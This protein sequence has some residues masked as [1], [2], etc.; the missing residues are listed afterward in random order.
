M[1]VHACDLSAWEVH[2]CRSEVHGPP[3]SYLHSD[4]ENSLGYTRPVL[5]PPPHTHTRSR[6]QGMRRR[7]SSKGGRREQ[8]GD[9]EQVTQ[10]GRLF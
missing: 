6:R 8:E 7:K 9:G 2:T 5:N 1:V 4:F 3:H 10:S